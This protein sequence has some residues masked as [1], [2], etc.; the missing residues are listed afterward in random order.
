MLGWRRSAFHYLLHLAV[1][2]VVYFGA[3]KVGLTMSCVHGTIAPVW[4]PTGLAVGAL[5]LGGPRRL[6][7]AIAAGAF[8]ANFDAGH[9]LAVAAAIA[10]GNTLEAVLGQGQRMKP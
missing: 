6:W 5:A 2:T 4:P 8:W 7:P 1:L 10:A 9:T 3:A